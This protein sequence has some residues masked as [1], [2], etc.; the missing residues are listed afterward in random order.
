M[1]EDNLS[2]KATGSCLCGAV[3]YEVDRPLRDVVVCHCAMCRKTHGHFAAYSAAPKSA[4][5]VIESRGL[6]WYRSS[7]DARRG[8]CC[9]CGGSLFWEADAKDYVSIAA[10]TLASPTGL[11]TTLQ[12]YVD[13]AGDYYAID[14]A[15]PRRVQ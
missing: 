10:G 12:I 3:V 6:R 2:G 14:D 8:F 9:E 7:S 11:K 5:R 15:I 13:H 1:S 4:L